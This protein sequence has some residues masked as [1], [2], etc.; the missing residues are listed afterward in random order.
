MADSIERAVLIHAGTTVVLSLFK[1]PESNAELRDPP[2][3]TDQASCQPPRA[4]NIRVSGGPKIDEVAKADQRYEKTAGPSFVPK[5]RAAIVGAIENA[6]PWHAK[7]AHVAAVKATLDL[8]AHWYK[9]IT[10]PM[11]KVIAL[12]GPL[13]PNLSTKLAQKIRPSAFAKAP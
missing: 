3:K 8:A 4:H 10:R 5:V 9:A 6:P 12:Q 1:K 11:M 7:I 13:K 2:A